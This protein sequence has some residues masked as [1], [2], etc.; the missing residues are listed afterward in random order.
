VTFA[1]TVTN[2]GPFGASAVSLIGDAYVFFTRDRV[3]LQSAVST[4]G[5][6][7]PGPALDCALGS[8]AAGASAQVLATY[9]VP[10][11][12]GGLF[13]DA[14]ALGAELDLTSTNN[15]ASGSVAAVPAPVTLV[16][17]NTN[18]AGPGSLR[19]AVT[20]ANQNAPAYDTITFAIAGTGPHTIAPETALP[21]ITDAVTIDGFSQPGSSPGALKI[22]LSGA[23]SGGGQVGLMIEAGGSL[24]RGLAINRFQNGIGLSGG[25]GNTIVGNHLG[26]DVT[27]A[28][29]LPNTDTGVALWDSDKNAIGGTSPGDRNVISG[30]NGAGVSIRGS[31]TDNVIRGNYI[32]TDATGSVPLPNLHGVSLAGAA[33]PGNIV[34]GPAPG[35]R[36]VISGNEGAGVLFWNGA[37]G[38]SVEGNFIGTDADG[39]I[40]LP[41]VIGVSVSGASGNTIGGAAPGQGNVISGNGGDGVR[42]VGTSIG[43]VVEGNLIGVAADGE[44]RRANGVNGITLDGDGVS[45]S[46]IR[47]NA[48]SGN[49]ATGVDIR[50][51][52]HHNVVTGNFVGTN[53]VGDDIGNVQYGVRVLNTSDNTI[54]VP[55]A[56][57]R[58]SDNGIVGVILQGA[59]HTV[60]Q[61]NAVVANGGA[62][63]LLWNASDNLIGGDTTAGEPNTIT[64]NAMGVVVSGASL[65][66]LLRE[67]AISDNS[68]LG[69]DLG[70]AIGGDGV[71]ANDA[72]DTDT[73]PND[74]LNF[75]VLDLAVTDGSALYVDGSVDIGIPGVMFSVEFFASSACDSSGHGEG[76]QYLGSVT[77]T[78]GIGGTT[79]FTA[80]PL[81]AVPVGRYITATT[82][83]GGTSEFSACRIVVGP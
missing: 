30:N 40:A 53:A 43:T 20:L 48:I 81:P 39:E 4:Q 62:G 32:G 64:S 68:G 19:E 35:A 46:T 71:T 2:N 11:G 65:R 13:F 1:L 52:A 8:L 75:P 54:G 38:N 73:G 14:T 23:L 25:G 78:T 22:E 58:I 5:T 70:D 29:E 33:G 67:N 74:L 37:Q 66:N 55:G 21:A 27:G 47:R 82:R 80:V 61:A 7:T 50:S 49:A 77:L 10:P 44:T 36:N 28:A 24:V 76:A 41:N 69:I 63:V 45:A 51:G 57:N 42:V 18:D 34:G 31:S 60:V 6:C 56:G 3:A 16:V 79:A 83:A 59:A 15:L 26:T 9:R 17:T 72:G 12:A